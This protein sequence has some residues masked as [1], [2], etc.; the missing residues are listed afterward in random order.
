MF[1]HKW[2]TSNTLLSPNNNMKC[3]KL[4]LHKHK[5]LA[6]ACSN[7]QPQV[8]QQTF[9]NSPSMSSCSLTLLMKY[10]SAF[11][12]FPRAVYMLP[13]CSNMVSARGSIE[14]IPISSITSSICN[15][16]VFNS[17]H[18]EEN[19]TVSFPSKKHPKLQSFIIEPSPGTYTN[20]FEF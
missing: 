2:P 12:G 19:N 17:D 9:R 14:L 7:Q 6:K 1:Y 18:R 5:R 10:G 8:T 13:M 15:Y 11:A 4:S 16:V 20:C 3:L